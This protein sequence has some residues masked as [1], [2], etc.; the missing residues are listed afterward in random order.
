MFELNSAQ[1]NFE[2]PLTTIVHNESRLRP[3]IAV[4]N[5][6]DNRCERICSLEGLAHNQIVF[7]LPKQASY[8]ACSIPK[9]YEVRVELYSKE[10]ESDDRG[11]AVPKKVIFVDVKTL[12]PTEESVREALSAYLD[13]YEIGGYCQPEAKIDEQLMF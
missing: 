3:T 10:S 5:Q 9:I 7:G 1:E 4:D 8:I 11:Y 13:E 2:Q 12:S 6:L